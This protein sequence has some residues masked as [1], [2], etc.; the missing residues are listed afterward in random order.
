M[1]TVDVSGYSDEI[2]HIPVICI[3]NLSVMIINNIF[4]SAMAGP[5]PFLTDMET[6]EEFEVAIERHNM[7]RNE[8]LDSTEYYKKNPTAPKTVSVA[9]KANHPNIIIP[10]FASLLEIC[11]LYD[12]NVEQRR[13]LYVSGKSLLTAFY[14]DD[15]SVSEEV[16]LSNQTLLFIHG[17]GGSGK[18]VYIRSL[19]GLAASWLRPDAVM[20]CAP[21][22]NAAVNVSG[23]TIE[24]LIRKKKEFFLKVSILFDFVFIAYLFSS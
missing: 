10:V 13:A 11:K 1:G 9:Y 14:N 20:T 16:K 19:I 4:R 23:Y 22:G 2:V 5:L 7:N 15:N 8:A 6:V 12:L 17:L 24:S 18:S 3:R 21:T